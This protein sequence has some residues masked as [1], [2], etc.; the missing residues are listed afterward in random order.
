[1]QKGIF[2]TVSI[3]IIA[4]VVVFIVMQIMP[5]YKLTNPPV[6]AEP[7]WDSPE[8]RALAKR[9]CFDCHSN[10][11]VWPW[12]AHIAPV[13]WL[14]AHDVMKGRAMFNFSQWQSGELSGD[15]LAG[16]I[17]S[18]AMPLLQYRMMHPEARLDEQEKQQLINGFMASIK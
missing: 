3:I 12:Y 4:A 18:G 13:K 6:T 5:V 16:A 11:T 1:M 14:V 10:E 2:R 15:D 9:A 7:Q 8:T 17:T